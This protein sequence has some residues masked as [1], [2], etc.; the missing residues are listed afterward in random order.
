MHGGAVGS[1]APLGNRNALTNGLFSAEELAAWKRCSEAL[2][3]VRALVTLI[4][5]LKN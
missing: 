3:D 2:K 1:G 5:Y 4:N